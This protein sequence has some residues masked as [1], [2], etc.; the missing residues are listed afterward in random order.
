MLCAT[1]LG[2]RFLF[3]LHYHEVLFWVLPVPPPHSETLH[4]FICTT[5]AVKKPILPPTLVSLCPGFMQV[6][7]I[8]ELGKRLIGL[9]SADSSF[10]YTVLVS[11]FFPYLYTLPLF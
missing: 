10:Q 2:L 7:G 3:L 5:T 6:P 4:L 1:G 11:C 8:P 9:C